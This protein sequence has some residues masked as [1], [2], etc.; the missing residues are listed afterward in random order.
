MVGEEKEMSEE[1]KQPAEVL[2]EVDLTLLEQAIQ[3]HSL[4][5]RSKLNVH[6]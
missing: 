6:S 2:S 4:T 3:R 1:E 5:N